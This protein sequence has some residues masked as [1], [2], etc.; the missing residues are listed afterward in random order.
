MG[1]L[2]RYRE[3]ALA[4]N[5]SWEEIRQKLSEKDVSLGFAVPHVGGTHVRQEG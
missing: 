4:P 2:D 3:R 5:S 1:E